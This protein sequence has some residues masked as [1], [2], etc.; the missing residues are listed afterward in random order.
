VTTTRPDPGTPDMPHRLAARPRDARRGLPV[1]P[2]NL[3]PDPHSATPLVDFTTI[4]ITASTELATG[5]RCSLCG[6]NIGYWV[7]FFNGARAAELMLY[8]DPPGC[9][10][11]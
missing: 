9:P 8:A 11:A 10:D 7:A 6:N 4:N 2:V 3:H 1:P 5:R